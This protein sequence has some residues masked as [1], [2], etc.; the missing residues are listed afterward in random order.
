[1]A[2][3]GHREGAGA[4]VSCGPGAWRTPRAAR[5]ARARC[6]AGRAAALAGIR[7]DEG[8][9][10]LALQNGTKVATPCGRTRTYFHVLYK[11]DTWRH[12]DV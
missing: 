8:G 2:S 3:N 10:P 6:A 4:R 9:A 5:R 11:A 12:A 7:G 1:M